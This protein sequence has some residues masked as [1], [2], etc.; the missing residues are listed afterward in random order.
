[1]SSADSPGPL[2]SK[3]SA[4][5]IIDLDETLITVNSFRI[6]ADYFLF[7]KFNK[8]TLP[9]HYLLSVKAAKILVER[10]AF[11]RSHA[12]T[13]A[14]LHKLWLEADDKNAL[15][16]ILISLERR[17]RPNMGDVVQLIS[18]NKIDALLATA[19][20]SVY[21]EPFARRVGFS[22][23]ISTKL[24]Q[25]ENRGEEKARNVQEF[26]VKQGW[27]ERKKIFFTDHLEDMPFIMKSD[28]LMWFGKGEEIEDI[29]KSAAGLE[30]I[31]CND[32]SAGE[33]INHISQ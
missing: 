5:L 20:A 30:I 21:A 4:V 32:L 29:K 1:M 28:K 33:I 6:W 12:Q 8:L 23:V 7:G 22:H 31:P 14:A 3:A 27:A 9:Q 17:I 10:K 13:K 24:G 15:E 2:T 25:K 11:G 18:G 26:L 16:N 19:A